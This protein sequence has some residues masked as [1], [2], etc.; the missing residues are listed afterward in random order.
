MPRVIITD[1][2]KNYGAAWQH[3]SLKNRAGHS[4]YPTRQRERR[5]G[6]CM[7]PGQ[8][9]RFLS[10]YGLMTS[11]CRPQRHRLSAPAYRQE[12]RQRFQAWPEVTSSAMA[13]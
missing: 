11:H 2:L 3:R 1:R 12:R 5:M 6:L 10:T 9:Q 7:S 8:A 13:T 4:H